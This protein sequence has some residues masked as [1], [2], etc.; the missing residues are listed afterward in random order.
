MTD[1]ITR[2]VTELEEMLSAEV[3]CGGN[4]FPRAR[5]CP[6]K[7]PA[8]VVGPAGHTHG[9]PKSFKCLDCFTEW[10]TA[11]NRPRPGF[12]VC[13]GQFIPIAGAYKPL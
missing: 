5:P 4:E 7:A 2:E 8:V 6:H 11:D 12:F 3:P 1:T 10:I 9:N 13:C